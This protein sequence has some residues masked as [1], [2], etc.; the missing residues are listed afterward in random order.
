MTTI[1]IVEDNH[2]YRQAIAMFLNTLPNLAVTDT[3][4]TAEDA[5]AGIAERPVD[6]AI[7]DLH[8]A[9]MDGVTLISRLSVSCPAIKFLVC[10]I[11]DNN[12]AVFEALR[13]GADG[14]ILKNANLA[15]IAA[16]VDELLKGGAPMSAFIARKV[17]SYFHAAP[18]LTENEEL[19][20]REMEILRLLSKGLLGK[21]I[22]EQLSI[23]KE[24]VKKH[25]ANIYRKMQV[26]NR[27]EAVNKYLGR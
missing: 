25:L 22:A 23:Q 6:I 21:E 15:E 2:E 9:E 24:T 19:S 1:A 20:M 27:M 17:L 8:L 7:V 3:Y 26:K 10:S 12:N 4:A 16:A 11:Q 18:P 14:Y 5:L 13:A